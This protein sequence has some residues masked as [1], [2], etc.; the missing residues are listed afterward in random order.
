[1]T[2]PVPNVPQANDTVTT[3][4]FANRDLGRI[5][6]ISI[7]ILLAVIPYGLWELWVAFF[8]ESSDSF[9]A[10]FGVVFVGGGAI[11]LNTMWPENRDQVQWFDA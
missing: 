6:N 10:L 7:A 4:V 11:G 2:P 9:G 3:R 8:S 5:T 1:M